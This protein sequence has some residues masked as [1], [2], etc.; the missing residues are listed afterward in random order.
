M[1][2]IEIKNLCF[3]YQNE[4]IINDLSINIPKN[5]FLAIAG[6]NGV[7][8][9]TLLNIICK[10]LHPQ[11]GTISILQKN[12]HEYTTTQL[13]TKIAMVNQNSNS[14][15]S[16]S[17]L[18]TVMMARTP[19][20]KTLGFETEND[21]N[22]VLDALKAADVEKFA[23]RNLHQLSSGEKQRVLIARALAQQTDIILLDEQT[24]F[25]DYKHQVRIYDLLKKLQIE[26]NKTI[27][28]ITHDINLAL[29]YCDKILFLAP[30]KTY[31]TPEPQDALS[32]EYLMKVFNAKGFI[33]SAGS[34]KFFLPMGKLAKDHKS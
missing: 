18:Q 32:D 3:K 4:Q 15:F 31:L 22:I 16:F 21:R 6:P 11:K 14:S 20:L 13:A 27:I 24:S 23:D 25:L 1:N 26:N 17:V 2:A 33:G 7:G 5:S 12:I 30:D 8:K 34:Q 10:I 9:S 19:Y 29:Q 28:T